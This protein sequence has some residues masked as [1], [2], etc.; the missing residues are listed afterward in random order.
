[1]DGGQSGCRVVDVVDG[2]RIGGGNGAGLSR[3]SRD[4]AEGALDVLGRIITDMGPSSPAVDAVVVGVTGL[5]DS[6]PAIRRFVDG[7]QSLVR[8]DRVVL[9]NDAVTSYL[10]A[11]GFEAS[12]VAAGTGVISLA[13]DRQGNFTRGDGWGY[14]LGDDGGGYYVGRRGLASALRSHDGRGGSEAIAKRAT[15]TFGTPQAIKERVY[16]AEN[17]AQ[18]VAGFALRVAEAAREGDPVAVMTWDDAARELASTV[19][20]TLHRIFDA[21]TLVPVSWAGALFG[22]RELILD[23]FERYLLQMRPAAYL[24]APKGTALDG[25]EVRFSRRRICRPCS[26]L[27][28]TCVL[29]ASIEKEPSTTPGIPIRSPQRIRVPSRARSK[30]LESNAA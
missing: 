20:A 16:G 14:I 9:T 11:I 18:E 30:R 29:K 26:A 12:V 4:R 13:G 19:T 28:Y 3:H 17:P 8:T 7:I 1:M 22:A 21:R 6:Q 15:E 5:E 25:A 10:G 27:W 24:L 23:P 2:D